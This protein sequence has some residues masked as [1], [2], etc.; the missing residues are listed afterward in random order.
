MN[1]TEQTNENEKTNDVAML[2]VTF[3]YGMYVCL[4]SVEVCML[5]IIV[6]F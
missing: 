4:S 6:M 1:G 5:N 3:Y 2:Y